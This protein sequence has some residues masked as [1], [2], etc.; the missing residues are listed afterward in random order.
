[1]IK[2]PIDYLNSSSCFLYLNLSFN[3]QSMFTSNIYSSETRTVICTTRQASY[4]QNKK[5]N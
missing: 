5:L 4:E 1:M 3:V 2:S